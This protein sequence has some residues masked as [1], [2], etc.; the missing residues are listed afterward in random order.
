M[1]EMRSPLRYGISRKPYV[2]APANAKVIR[3]LDRDAAVR[4]DLDADVRV[5]SS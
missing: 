2:N 3:L 5:T 4:L 1:S